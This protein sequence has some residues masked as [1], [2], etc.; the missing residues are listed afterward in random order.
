[1]RPKT[2]S[3]ESQFLTDDLIQEANTLNPLIH[4]LRVEI[5]K[6]WNAGKHDA[7]PVPGFRIEFLQ[8]IN[9]T[10][11][12]HKLGY[13]SWNISKSKKSETQLLLFLGKRHRHEWGKE[14]ELGKVSKV[15]LNCKFPYVHLALLTEQKV[16][17]DM[18][19]K[20]IL[21]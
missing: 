14:W 18:I 8:E 21:E 9:D 15:N 7:D 5:Y 4:I 20:N 13:S 16:A 3:S 17:G 10:K 19:R 1:V 11:K 2:E 12:Y 6:L